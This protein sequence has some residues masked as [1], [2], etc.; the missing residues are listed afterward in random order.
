MTLTESDIARFL[1]K[2]DM[3]GGHG[4]CW[5][6]KGAL[7]GKSKGSA[8]GGASGERGSF[9]L[10]GKS[11]HAHKVA[12]VIANGALPSG[13]VLHEC[14]NRVCCNPAHLEDGTQGKNL[15]DAY[16]RGRRPKLRP[17][18]SSALRHD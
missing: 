14:D 8:T 3:S 1:V 4:A 15:R 13:V 2:V 16:A 12:F 10:K 6:W 9:K 18:R 11:T 7:T 17:N 5:P